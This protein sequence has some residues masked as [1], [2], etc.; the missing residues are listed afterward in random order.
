MVVESLYRQEDTLQMLK[1]CR[2]L[3]H[4]L[5]YYCVGA[6]PILALVMEKSHLHILDR[7]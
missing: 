3:L 5:G 2:V 4:V 7:S 1:P 6:T